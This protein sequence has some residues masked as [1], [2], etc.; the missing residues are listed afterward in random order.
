[1]VS[2]SPVEDKSIMYTHPKH[3]FVDHNSV[4]LRA[5]GSSGMRYGAMLSE[6]RPMIVIYKS[7]VRKNETMNQAAL[8]HLGERQTEVHFESP[9]DYM[10]FLEVLCSIHRSG[11]FFCLLQ[12]P[13]GC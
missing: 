12:V 6:I 4:L 5:T 8:A 11:N 3:D 2:K 7:G 9:H 1:L 13:S 10:R